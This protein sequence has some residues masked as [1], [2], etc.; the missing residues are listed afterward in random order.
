MMSNRVAF[1][2]AVWAATSLAAQ[3]MAQEGVIFSPA[4]TETCMQDFGHLNDLSF[5]AGEA[6][7]ACMEA[8]PGGYST[9]GMVGCYDAELQYWDAR[10]NGAY[11]RVRAEAK[12]MDAEMKEIG[13]SAPS[14]ADALRDMQRAWI[15]YR[16]ATC[17][18]ERTLWGGG[19][20]AGPA[21][22]ACLMGLTAKQALYLEGLNGLN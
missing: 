8:T 14:Q 9:V 5:C 15:T 17:G 11:K 7:N 12:A 3:G 4:A 13:S 2:V 21:G 10:L 6:A 20:G 1:A 19:T 16:D 22:V 18:Y